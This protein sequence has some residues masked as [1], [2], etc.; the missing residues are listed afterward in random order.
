MLSFFERSKK[1]LQFRTRDPH[2]L[3]RFLLVFFLHKF[4]KYKRGDLQGSNSR[5]LPPR[6][7][8]KIALYFS[9]KEPCITLQK[10]PEFLYQKPPYF[11]TKKPHISPEKDQCDST[12]SPEFLR[13]RALHVSRKEPC[14]SLHKIPILLPKRNE[15]PPPKSPVFLHNRAKNLSTKN[16]EKYLYFPPPNGLSSYVEYRTMYNIIPC[17][18]SLVDGNVGVLIENCTI[19]FS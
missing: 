5:N 13:K 17:I 3:R 11:S 4:E 7:L 15:F 2:I 8:H 10:S 1:V 14:I 12:K 19:H 16:H 9:A 6:F 18:C